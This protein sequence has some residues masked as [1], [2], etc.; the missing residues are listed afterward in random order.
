M[1][2][3]R[4]GVLKLGIAAILGTAV[5][6]LEQKFAVSTTVAASGQWEIVPN[7]YEPGNGSQSFPWLP[8]DERGAINIASLT[9]YERKFNT[10]LVEGGAL[11]KMDLLDQMLHGDRARI[12]YFK[13]T[14]AWLEETLRPMVNSKNYW[15]FGFCLD[16][17]AASKFSPRIV[18]PTTIIVPQA[19]GTNFEITFDEWERKTIATLGYAGMLREPRYKNPSPQQWDELLGHYYQG[20]ALVVQYHPT[21]EWWGLVSSVQTDGMLSV[22]Q[23]INYKEPDLQSRDIHLASIYAAAILNPDQPDPGREGPYAIVQRPLRGLILGTHR[24]VRAS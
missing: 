18:G 6:A 22:T 7:D 11:D 15:W 8:P 13:S 17:V 1:E 16:A 10:G 3:T 14:R 5:A 21:E 2:Y 24:I 12:S 20:E 9:W 4:R 23:H 19:D